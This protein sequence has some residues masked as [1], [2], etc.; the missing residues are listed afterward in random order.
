[1]RKD[2]CW[3]L[4]SRSN[5]GNRISTTNSW[6]SS[7]DSVTSCVLFRV[8][9]ASNIQ[10]SCSHSFGGNTEL[11]LINVDEWF[12]VDNITFFAI[13][14]SLLSARY[15]LPILL[16][17]YFIDLFDQR[18]SQ[19]MSEPKNEIDYTLLE[20]LPSWVNMIQ[21]TNFHDEFESALS[22]FL[23]FMHTPLACKL[24]KLLIVTSKDLLMCLLI[25]IFT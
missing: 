24:C 15:L 23:C 20:W 6:K 8:F 19:R 25:Q 13:I 22:H 9:S 14:S 10:T 18:I 5:L 17:T 11:K 1:M 4:I 21:A 3:P 16:N 2:N 12:I 7:T